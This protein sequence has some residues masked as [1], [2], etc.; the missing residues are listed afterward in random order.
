MGTSQMHE[1]T[2]DKN[3]VW[4]KWRSVESLWLPELQQATKK[5]M[6]RSHSP[7]TEALSEPLWGPGT[8][9]RWVC[10]HATTQALYRENPALVSSNL[11][12]GHLLPCSLSSHSSLYFPSPFAV[13][14]T[15]TSASDGPVVFS[16][17]RRIFLLCGGETLGA[18]L[19]FGPHISFP[20][21]K[22]PLHCISV[23][24]IRY[25]HCHVCWQRILCQ[26]WHWSLRGHTGIRDPLLGS[27]RKRKDIEPLETIR[28]VFTKGGS[29]RRTMKDE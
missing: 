11:T 20:G 16:P 29:L 17:P 10:P 24:Q 23:I 8:P 2:Y 1:E 18:F 28:A 22:C 9:T 26:C 4:L 15:L 12:A 5:S 6:L 25:H 27:A 3:P 21:T 13:T 14:F 7:S 19:Y